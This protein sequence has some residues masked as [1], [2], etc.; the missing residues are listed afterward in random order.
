[1]ELIGYLLSFLLGILAVSIYYKNLWCYAK[2]KAKREKIKVKYGENSKWYLYL[3]RRFPL[4]K[5]NIIFRLLLF[6]VFATFTL[7]V[8]GE[9]PF[10]AFVGGVVF[11]NLALFF[12]NFSATQKVTKRE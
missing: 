3:K 5:C 8:F 11:G 6:L 2:V 1:M 12:L 10:L 7:R 4:T 9:K